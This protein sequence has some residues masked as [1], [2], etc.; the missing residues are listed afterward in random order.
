MALAAWALEGADVEIVDHGVPWGNVVAHGTPVVLHDP[1]CP[2]TPPDW[3]A[4]CVAA[5]LESGAVVAGV[6]P[7]TD[8]VKQV[9]EAEVGATVDRHGLVGVCSP[10]V[11]P[12]A[13]VAE[14]AE[15]LPTTDFVRL[16]A[17]LRQ[18]HD[19]R[20]LRAPA[21]AR[22]V[23]SAEDLRVLAALTAEAGTAQ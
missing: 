22:R 3:I 2:M 7:V 19:T 17:L 18:R 5:S 1:L 23:A 21:A 11:V 4:A 14:F 6:R 13:V 8:T 16:T 12:T 10:I 20:T 9:V 15:G